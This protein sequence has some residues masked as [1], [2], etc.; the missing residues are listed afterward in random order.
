MKFAPF[1]V[2]RAATAFLEQGLVFWEPD[3]KKDT[4]VKGSVTPQFSR[5]A[6]IFQ[7]MLFNKDRHK[8]RCDACGADQRLGKFAHNC[9]FLLSGKAFSCFQ[10]YDGHSN[11][12]RSSKS[13]CEM[14]I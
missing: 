11:V 4:S 12:L 2:R 10:N 8:F 14:S 6:D 9:S 1:Q 13:I 5:F 7:L 3:M